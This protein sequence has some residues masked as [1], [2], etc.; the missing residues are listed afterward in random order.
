MWSKGMEDFAAF[1]A[2]KVKRVAAEERKNDEYSSG[3][4]R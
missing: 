3:E 2:N 1:N 4:K